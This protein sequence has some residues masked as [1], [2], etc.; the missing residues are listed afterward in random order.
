MFGYCYQL[1]GQ[2][3]ELLASCIDYPIIQSADPILST[4]TLLSWSLPN[5]WAEEPIDI[6]KV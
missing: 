4:R 6:L 2:H 3:V 5:V 1:D